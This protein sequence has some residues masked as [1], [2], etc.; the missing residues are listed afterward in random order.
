MLKSVV[1][2]MAGFGGEQASGSSQTITGKVVSISY[3]GQNKSRPA[4]GLGQRLSDARASVVWEGMPAGIVAS[5]GKAYQ[6]I[7]GL[8]ANNNAKIAP[9]LGQTVTVNG[10]V[11]EQYGMLV[12]SAD[13]AK[14]AGK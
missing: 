7:G 13:S 5:D 12:I 14:A 2:F 1:E 6:A 10:N 4:G 9:F 3:Y 11:S 8:A